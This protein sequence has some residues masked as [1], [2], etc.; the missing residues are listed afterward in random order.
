MSR[1]L[2]ERM[3]A[4]ELPDFLELDGYIKQR[5]E[6]G[7]E[8]A[9]EATRVAERQFT[10]FFPEGAPAAGHHLFVGRDGQ[11]GNRI[12]ILWLHQRT[13]GEANHVFIYDVEV[14]ESA[15]GRGWG[16]ELMQY[17]EAW[18]LD[19]GA[20]QIELNVFGGNAVARGLYRSLGYLESSVHMTKTLA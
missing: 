12:G 13:Q 8:D 5:V 1:L 19:Q 4:D 10:E 2:V 20:A 17:A 15:R 11:T 16:R 14:E 18:A 3:T 9:A 6:F 7:G